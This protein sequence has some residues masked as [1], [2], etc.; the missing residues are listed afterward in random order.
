MVLH[1]EIEEVNQVASEGLMFPLAETK[2]KTCQLV[3]GPFQ[4]VQVALSREMPIW[5]DDP[6]GWMLPS[7]ESQIILAIVRKSCL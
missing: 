3:L 7:P 6:T 5:M 2:E 4:S 1:Q